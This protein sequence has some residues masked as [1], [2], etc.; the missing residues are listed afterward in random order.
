MASRVGNFQVA[1][2]VDP[3][4]SHIEL[5]AADRVSKQGWRPRR[6]GN[7]TLRLLLS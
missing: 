1:E 4:F 7:A 6:H 2:A 5:F 3:Q